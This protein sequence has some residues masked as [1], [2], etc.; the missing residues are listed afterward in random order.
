MPRGSSGKLNRPVKQV[1]VSKAANESGRVTN[2]SANRQTAT[3]IKQT[4]DGTMCLPRRSMI[5]PINQ[6]QRKQSEKP[7][8]E[9]KRDAPQAELNKIHKYRMGIFENATQ[10]IDTLKAVPVAI[11]PSAPAHISAL[12]ISER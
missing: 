8:I 10:N 12:C 7:T 6:K 4:S 1:T 2:G 9:R 3:P 11:V 5:R